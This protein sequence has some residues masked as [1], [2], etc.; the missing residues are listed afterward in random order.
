MPRKRSIFAGNTDY[1]GV[2]IDDIIYHLKDI[3]DLTYDTIQKLQ[4]YRKKAQ[5]NQQKLNNPRDV[6]NC[7]DYLSDLFN[8][9]LG[10][11]DILVKELN[12]S[13]EE[14]HIEII[15]QILSSNKSEETVCVNF[16]R[17]NINDQLKDESMR[18]LLDIIYSN[19][20]GLF[21]NYQDLANMVIRLKTFVGSSPKS[22]SSTDTSDE[23]FT[24]KFNL[25]FLTGDL[26]KLFYILCKWWKE[27]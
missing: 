24:F 10:D 13:V 18:G 2:G 22:D 16:A 8:R 6:F 25:Y 1:A 12:Y 7:I 23:I 14:R 27:I 19:S 5:L 4:S 11:L 15:N 3:R 20:R 9:Y 26:K 17:E 21:I